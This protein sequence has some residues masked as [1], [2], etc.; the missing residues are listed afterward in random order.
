MIGTVYL[1]H[2]SRPFGHA[3]HYLGHAVNLERRLEEHARGRGANLVRH[4]LAAGIKFK[5]ARTWE[6]VDRYEER[7][8]KNRGGKARM[9]PLCRARRRRSR[10]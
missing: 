3:K 4:A 1:L 5:L 6:G 7:R 10:A 9:C 2:F 8:L